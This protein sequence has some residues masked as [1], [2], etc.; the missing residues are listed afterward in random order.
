VTAEQYFV[1]TIHHPHFTLAV[2]TLQ[3][4]L[5]SYLAKHQ[6]ASIDYV[7]GAEVVEELGK[8]E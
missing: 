2:G 4:F 8:K 7:H 3:Q 1:L 5:D 6:A